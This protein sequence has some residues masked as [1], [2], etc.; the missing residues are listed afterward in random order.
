MQKLIAP[1]KEEVVVV[2]KDEESKHTVRMEEQLA[3]SN[4]IN[5]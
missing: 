2:K 1:I 4:W 5:M 3:F